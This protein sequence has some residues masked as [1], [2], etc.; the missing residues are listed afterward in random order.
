MAVS[1]KWWHQ[2]KPVIDV[3][4]KLAKFLDCELDCNSGHLSVS[5]I[6]QKLEPMVHQFLLLLIQHQGSIVS[7]QKVIGA[8]WPNKEPTDET[9]RALI[10]K[11]REALKDNARNPSYINTIPTKGYLFIPTVELRS[12]IVQSWVL[13]HVKILVSSIVILALLSLMLIWY[14]YASST[15]SQHANNIIITKTKIGTINKNKVSTHYINKALK[16]MWIEESEFTNASQLIIVDVS[17]KFELKITF[18]EALDKQFW[19]SSGSQRV[20]V[21]RNDNKGFYSVQF[22]RQGNGPNIIEHKIELPTN[23]SIS[24]LDYNGN[25]VFVV[26][27]ISKQLTLFDLDTAELLEKPAITN[28]HDQLRLAQND[29]SKQ[30]VQ[31]LS[32]K[33]WP[34][35]ATEGLMISFAF[36]NRTRLLYYSS[37]EAK[38]PLSSV[39]I[40]SGLQSAVWN[41]TGKRFSFTDDNSNLFGLQ[42]DEGRLTSFNANGEPVNKVLADCGSNCFVVANTQGIPKLS[43]FANPFLLS[44]TDNFSNVNNEPYAQV[45]QTN[46]IARNEYLPHYTAQ[47]LYFVSQQVGKTEIVFRDH[48]N[49]EQV[50]FGFLAQAAVDEL[51]VDKDDNYLAGMVNQRLFLLN[52]NTQKLSYI[53]VTFPHVS[54]IRFSN[55]NSISF[56]AESASANRVNADRDQ[57]SGLY[58]YNIDTGE[59]KLVSANIKMQDSIEL[60]DRNEMGSTRYTATVR[61]GNRGELSVAFQNNR[62]ATLVNLGANDCVSCWRIKDN[63]L[64]QISPNNNDGPPSIMTRVDLL[65]GERSQQVLLFYDVLNTFSLHPRTN[66][67]IVTTR[68][69]LQTELMKI[70]GFAQVY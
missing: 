33:V 29:F 45:I 34:S 14:F 53:P 6:Q 65:T 38:A 28:I 23:T 15:S 32:I 12:T 4:N 22:D 7:K 68:Q 16:S 64:Y 67:V 43:E 19:Y 62:E 18:S 9:L 37:M 54:H 20:L 56:Y 49:Q 58:H 36:A 31:E 44:N 59:S 46:S 51:F 66:K 47:G 17:T 52:L 42:V 41:T 50:V 13:Q 57:A 39:D 8:L 21:M 24:A 48:E 3:R 70:E 2:L 60:V 55:N 26:S 63:Y 25:N 1:I 61:L 27:D 69:N 11:T 10:K 35:P 30:D 40:G 5:G